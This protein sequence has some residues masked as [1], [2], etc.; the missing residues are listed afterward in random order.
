MTYPSAQSDLDDD[1]MD[2][3]LPPEPSSKS[4]GKQREIYPPDN[5]TSPV[6]PLPR[7]PPFGLGITTSGMT[8][9]SWEGHDSATGVIAPAGQSGGSLGTPVTSSA[10][11]TTSSSSFHNKSA[12]SSAA[13][14]S[15]SHNFSVPLR[16]ALANS[17][18][19]S[20]LATSSRYTSPSS[21]KFQPNSRTTSSTSYGPSPSSSS[22]ST[23]LPSASSSKSPIPSSW[24]SR[25]VDLSSQIPPQRGYVLPAT[26]SSRPPSQMPTPPPQPRTR[27]ASVTGVRPPLGTSVPVVAYGNRNRSGSGSMGAASSGTF[28]SR[29][30]MGARARSQSRSRTGTVNVSIL[31]TGNGSSSRRPSRDRDRSVD[32][33]SQKSISMPSSPVMKS[34]HLSFSTNPGATASASGP[35]G[36]SSASP[37]AFS[38]LSS[39]P[40]RTLPSPVLPNSSLSNFAY[41]SSSAAGPRSLTR[42]QPISSSPR[43]PSILTSSIANTTGK[44]A[45][46]PSPPSIPVGRPLGHR[47][48]SIPRNGAPNPSPRKLPQPSLA[49]HIASISTSPPR[50]ANF[51]ASAQPYM[52]PSTSSPSIN[53][54]PNL[55]TQSATVLPPQHLN[56][57]NDIL[58]SSTALSYSSYSA[59]S[60]S[61][62]RSS[63]LHSHSM[64]SDVVE[65]LASKDSLDDDDRSSLSSFRARRKGRHGSHP[66]LDLDDLSDHFDDELDD[67]LGAKGGLGRVDAQVHVHDSGLLDV[68][69]DDED[70]RALS[71]SPSPM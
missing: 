21:T 44:R 8:D 64:P 48:P 53:A 42:S 36:A 15:S 33:S 32:A 26:S 43:Q 71:R 9:A 18:S 3:C 46:P 30:V 25:P 51:A 22:A 38:P 50:A 19:Y 24:A 5:I 68:H 59:S 52:T 1:D 6:R 70:Y 2:T 7:V 13:T 34:I 12:R 17:N 62:G 37:G 27:V 20:S 55:R 60:S 45:L 49:A 47:E 66:S 40:P 63:D 29:T 10:S 16:S 39:R 23:N 4:K 35:S 11:S 31:P 28:G 14:S 69:V 61:I 56:I 54:Q 57:P 67:V 65:V 41:S 58:P